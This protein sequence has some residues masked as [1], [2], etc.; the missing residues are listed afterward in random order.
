VVEREV[1][2]FLNEGAQEDESEAESDRILMERLTAL[3]YNSQLR[4][5]LATRC[6]THILTN[7]AQHIA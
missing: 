7:F 1:W 2:R 6:I 5:V 3:N 4:D